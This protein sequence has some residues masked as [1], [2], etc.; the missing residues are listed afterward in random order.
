M[1][2]FRDIPVD[3]LRGLAIV[4]MVMANMAPALLQPPVPGWFRLLSSL[5]AP[6]FITTAGTMV[7]LSR[8]GRG[9]SFGYIALRGG[10]VILAGALL[11]LLVYAIVPFI[12]VDVLYLI[13]LSLPVV[14]LCLEL[15][16]RSRLIV[17]ILILFLAPVLWAGFGYNESLAEPTFSL[18]GHGDPGIPVPGPGDIVKRWLIDGW[19]P[20][21]P[22]LA[23]SLLGAEIGMYRW[24]SGGVKMF[25]FTREGRYAAGLLVLGGTLWALFPGAQVIRDGYVELFYPP[26]PGLLVFAAGFFLLVLTILDHFPGYY[27]LLDPLRAAGECSLALYLLHLI[28]IR[29][30]IVPAGI[31][32][33]VTEYILVYLVLMAGLILIAYLLRFIRKNWRHQPFLVRFLIGG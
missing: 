8:T 1:K 32:V 23:L 9:R 26:V 3:I 18:S 7:A 33:P 14:W 27:S 21:F 12:D 30:V 29:L 28:V 17:I 2:A 6:L 31:L 4:L 16:K 5:A 22:W 13:G 15:P 19:F 25:R 24:G 11:Q 10:L 20:V